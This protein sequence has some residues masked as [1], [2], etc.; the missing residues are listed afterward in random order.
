MRKGSNATVFEAVLRPRIESV[1]RHTP[2]AAGWMKLKQHNAKGI[3]G[4]GKGA[5]NGLALFLIQAAN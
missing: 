1:G 5:N 2:L 4:L 3:K